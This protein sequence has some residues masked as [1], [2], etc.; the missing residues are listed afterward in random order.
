MYGLFNSIE[1]DGFNKVQRSPKWYKADLIVPSTA[2]KLQQ[3]PRTAKRVQA[4]FQPPQICDRNQA[5]CGFS[6]LKQINSI[7]MQ[8]TSLQKQQLQKQVLAAQS[9]KN[10]FSPSVKATM[11]PSF[12][13]VIGGATPFTKK[14]SPV[15]SAAVQ[16]DVPNGTPLTDMNLANG[17]AIEQDVTIT[18]DTTALGNTT[19]TTTV[20]LFDESGMHDA[21]FAYTNTAAV[22]MNGSA[23]FYTAWLGGTCGGTFFLDNVL[24]NVTP[25]SAA[26][27]TAAMQY[28]KDIERFEHN[29][30]TYTSST[31]PVSNY[32]D[33]TYFNQSVRPIG[34]SESNARFDR[35]TAWS[36]VV[37]HGMVITL[38]FNVLAYQSGR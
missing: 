28:S 13:Q 35:T 20:V 19:A 21:R 18:I 7:E 10:R 3:G 37:Y 6:K 4:H 2:K 29:A 22:T 11:Q 33:P 16:V 23:A 12:A 8:I 27:A 5:Q 34:L 24:M 26:A 17:L 30:R 15:R 9:R 31:I 1:F 38:T 32:V 25:A 14:V 36:L